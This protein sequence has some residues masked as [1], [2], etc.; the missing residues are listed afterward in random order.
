MPAPWYGMV[1]YSPQGRGSQGSLLR[2]PNVQA[3]AE[4]RGRSSGQIVLRWHAQQ[5]GV[6]AIPNSANRKPAGGKH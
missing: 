4:R 1:S 6:I 3:K 2:N 5:R